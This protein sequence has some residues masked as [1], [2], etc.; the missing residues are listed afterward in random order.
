[1]DEKRT[2]DLDISRI[3][4]TLNRFCAYIRYRDGSIQDKISFVDKNTY[5]GR[6][7][8][9][10]SRIV[11]LAQFDLEYSSWKREWIGKNDIIR[12]RALKAM[13]RAGNLVNR[14]Q[15]IHFK[16]K[17]DPNRK[18]Y[19]PL[20]EQALYDIYT[21]KGAEEESAAFAQAQSVFG[22]TYDTLAFLWFIKDSSRFLPVSPGNFE[23]SLLSIGIEYKLSNRCSWEN[24][25]GFIDIVR[26]IQS[27]MQDIEALKGVDI[28]LI[29]A[30]SFLWVI[31]ENRPKDYR[32]WK[33]DEET[34]T[35]IEK[36]TEDYQERK[37]EGR[38]TRISRLTTTYARSV[39]VVK[40]TKERAKGICELCGQSAPF[41]DRKG[42]PYLETHHVVWLSHGG[43]DSTDNTVAL[44]PNC[45]TKIHVLNDP[46]DVE[47][48]N[49]KRGMK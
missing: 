9:Y 25:N 27:I 30:H 40:L 21:S 8:N 22:G 45:H 34:E 19:N 7:E 33:P 31:N 35:I 24:Y 36:E 11:E 16:D 44:C 20:A 5:L 26:S 3:V 43:K 47:K 12:N 32:N 42:Q 13:S 1:M 46:K 23:N 17:L 6:E 28:R 2:V 37:A 39:E 41:I 15:Q 18:E 38:G 48:L 10:K 49:T 4:S 29:D 14:N